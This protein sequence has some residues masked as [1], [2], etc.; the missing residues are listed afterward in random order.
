MEY[1][2]IKKGIYVFILESVIIWKSFQENM[3]KC[4]KLYNYANNMYQNNRYDAIK[5]TKLI[6]MANNF[7]QSLSYMKMHFFAVYNIE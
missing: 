4:F 2:Y 7:L 3:G 6:L 5:F 1:S